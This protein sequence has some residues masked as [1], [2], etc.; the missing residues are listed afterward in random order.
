MS[1]IVDTIRHEAP[2][3]PRASRRRRDRPARGN[4]ELGIVQY[5]HMGDHDAVE[6]ALEALAEL[7]IKHLRTSISWCDWVREGGEEWYAWLLPK[8][9]ERA[10]VLPCFL[11]TPPHLGLLPKSSSPPRDPQAFGEFVEMV[12]RCYPDDFPYVELWNEP[13]N[14]IEWDWTVDPE[15]VIFAEMIAGAAQRAARLGVKSVLG[16]MSP[17]DPNW[18][19]L[20]FKRGALAHI[21][22]IGVHG[23]PGTWEAVWEG[24]DVHVDRVLEVIARH[25]AAQR[26]WVTEAGYSTWAH[27]EF[28][29]LQTMADLVQA[30]ADR[31]YWY[32]LQDLAAEH[33]TLD[34]FHC[35]ERAYHFGMTRRDAEAK[36]LHRVMRDRGV[37]GVSELVEFAKPGGAAPSGSVLITGGAGFIGTNLAD[38]L[39]STGTAVT[40][41]DSLVRPGVEDN[42]RWLKRKH[43]DLVRVEIGDVRD[44]FTVR[45]A[46]A[47]AERVF[48]FAAQVAVTTSL[49][50]PRDDVDVNLQGTINVLEEARRLAAP[51][52]V[53][54]TSTNKVYGRLSQLRLRRGETRYEPEDESVARDGIAES[55]PLEFCSPYGCSK[56]AADQYVLDYAHSYGMRTCVLRMSCIYGP[57]QHGTEDQGWVAHFLLGALRGEPITIFGDGRQTRDLLY[58]QDLVDALLAASTHPATLEGRAFNIGG[59]AGN[60][61]SVIGVVQQISELLGQRPKVLWGAWRVADQRYYVSDI[62]AFSRLT[63][64]KPRVPVQIGI[65]RLYEWLADAAAPSPAALAA[66]GSS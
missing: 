47:G 46:L 55:W 56:G 16:G 53:V 64:W 24:W 7:P 15:W 19:D 28:G 23:F 11:Y 34:G 63:G 9:V 2:A 40:V 42:L 45:R 30:P 60:A 49:E 5:F 20:M 59:G 36:L 25:G 48:H 4:P 65:A 17:F 39:A 21:D 12:L 22:V 44:R 3:Q 13:N 31:V 18:L 57:H 35:D 10:A 14:Y 61:I 37:R 51:P 41:L 27:N 66:A 8:L 6:Q 52:A 1:R 54:F 26:I 38:R 43:R 32:S 50:H 62:S 33:E 29:Q 58:V